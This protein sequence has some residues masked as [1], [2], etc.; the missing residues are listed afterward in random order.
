M[1]VKN[2]NA[3]YLVKKFLR[4]KLGDKMKWIKIGERYRV[5]IE[6]V[7]CYCIPSKEPTTIEV[8]YVNNDN[9]KI[10]FDSE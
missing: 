9:D 6:A 3:N 7:R 8:K 1:L 5:D 2:Q 10:G 4:I